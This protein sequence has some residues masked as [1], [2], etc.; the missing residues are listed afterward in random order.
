MDM[1]IF[2]V[3]AVPSVGLTFVLF[4]WH[5]SQLIDQFSHY[6]FFRTQYLWTILFCICSSPCGDCLFWASVK[7][8]TCCP[9]ISFL[10]SHWLFARVFSALNG[11]KCCVT[12]P[13]HHLNQCW[14]F[15]CKVH[16]HSSGDNFTRELSDSNVNHQSLIWSWK[17]L[18]IKNFIQ[19]FQG[20]MSWFHVPHPY[21]FCQLHTHFEQ[22]RY[23]RLWL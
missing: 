21:M 2:M 14:Y 8:R 1:M 11:F 20:P 3:M 19:I 9:E 4:I 6:S 22:Y 13:G 15:K 23:E 17:L 10:L 16:W 18:S 5:T 12:A 7:K